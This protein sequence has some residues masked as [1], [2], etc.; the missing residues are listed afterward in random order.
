MSEKKIV[1]MVDTYSGKKKEDSGTVLKAQKGGLFNTRIIQQRFFVLERTEIDKVPSEDLE[2]I[3]AQ[4]VCIDDLKEWFEEA[5][6][7]LHFPRCYSGRTHYHKDKTIE[8][9]TFLRKDIDEFK[10]KL[11]KWFGEP[12][13]RWRRSR[14]PFKSEDFEKDEIK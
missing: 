14:R 2:I 13:I 10:A 5:K 8:T 1:E 3:G 9:V 12:H 7:D 6:Q 4:A 11:A